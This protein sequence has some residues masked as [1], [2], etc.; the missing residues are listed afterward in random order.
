MSAGTPPRPAT[1]DGYLSVVVRQGDTLERIA[2]TT[3]GY[4]GRWREIAALNNLA[5]PYLSDDPADW[6][7]PLLSQGLLAIQ[8]GAGATVIR[9]VGERAAVVAPGT[10]VLLD[11]YGT[12]AAGNPAYVYDARRVLT[13]DPASGNTALDGDPLAHAWPAG[14]RYR[15]Y[16]PAADVTTRVARTGDRLYLPVAPPARVDLVQAT[17]PTDLYGVDIALGADGR[18]AF[19]NGDLATVSGLANAAQALWIRAQLPLGSYLLHPDEGNECFALLGA[20]V[21]PATALFAEAALRQALASDPRVRS[22]DAVTATVTQ[23]DV[24]AVTATVV[25]ESTEAAIEVNAVAR[26]TGL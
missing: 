9:L 6:Y 19:A 11:G 8:A 1:P 15:V 4:A 17:T 22:V 21:G 13:F 7:G 23:P 18:L 5:F 10:L 16:P 2:A 14:T 3:L 26:G 24:I 20:P 12:N 25:L